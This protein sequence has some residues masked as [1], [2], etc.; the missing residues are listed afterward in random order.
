MERIRKK[1]VF[2]VVIIILGIFGIS[3]LTGSGNVKTKYQTAQ[4][5]RDSIISTISESGNV[6]S[7]N[8]TNVTSSTNG[9][10]TET[11][12]HNSDEVVTGQNLFKVKSTATPQEQAAAYASYLSAVNSEKTAEQSQLSADASMW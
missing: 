9:I 12:V 1:V 5:Q 11:Y 6:S 7:S 4:V 8:Q 3:K 2:F 10:L